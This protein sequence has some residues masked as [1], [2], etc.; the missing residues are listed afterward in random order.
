M[1]FNPQEYYASQGGISNPGTFSDRY[2][3]LPRD[4]GALTTAI[5]GLMLHV[6][7]ADKHEII[8]NRLRKAETNIR[9]A[10]ERIAKILELSDK[11]LSE[12]RTL[13]QRTIGT[14]RDFALLLASI[15]RQRKIPARARCGFGTYFTE[16]HFD[17][18]WVCEYWDMESERWVLVDGQLDPL[19]M[20]TL[21]IDFDPLDVPKDKFIMG[22]QAWQRCRLKQ[23]D[24]NRFGAHPIAGLFFVKD[25]LIRDFLA[26]NK[27]E[28]LPWDNY[29]LIAKHISKMTKKELTFLDRLATVSSGEDRDFLLLRATFTSNMDR[30]L[31]S[32]FFGG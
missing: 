26:L 5:Q 32:Y 7:W 27:V 15:L 23:V 6:H 14:C 19:Q 22:G 21:K 12:S 30:L 8:L 3:E 18:H 13:P 2:D 29:G 17:D 24:P 1:I 11:P 25:N 10:R 16:G 31:P 4:I 9:T 20:E 28:I